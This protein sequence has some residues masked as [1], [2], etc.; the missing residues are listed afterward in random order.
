MRRENFCK[1]VNMAKK[2]YYEILGVSRDA[3]QEEIK[4]AYRKLVLKYHPDR[5]PPE[6]KKEAEEKFKEISE[7][8]DVLSDPQKRKL[9]DM[10][11]TT[12]FSQ[13]TGYNFNW[14]EFF[15]THASDFS[16]LFSDIQH[17][18]ENLFGINLGRERATSTR[19]RRRARGK[20]I[21]YR[22]PL[23]LE[24]LARGVEK[25][26]SYNRYVT[27]PACGGTGGKRRVCPT[28]KGRGRVVR[29]SRMFGFVIQ[30]QT[31]CPTCGG[32]GEELYEK[33]PTCNGKGL[34]LKEERVKIR[35]PAG[36]RGGQRIVVPGKGDDG[37]EGGPAGDL[38]V[39]VEEK[40]HPVFRR[41]GDNLHMDMDITVSQAVVGDDVEIQDILGERIRIKIP[42]GTQPG[43]S[44]RVKGRGMPRVDGKGRGDLV[45]HLNVRVP[46][47]VNGKAKKL[48]EEL[49]K[50]GY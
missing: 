22:L 3:T 49:K 12:D 39:E 43:D 5:V 15:Q 26:I 50:M 46:K 47:K 6:K 8:Y 31:T 37:R 11:G 35:I 7:A 30:S 33:C 28:C 24:E 1:I 10:Y 13:Q 23:T 20:N 38:Y 41:E 45:V 16:D 17:I 42:E 44:I 2:D 32:T 18:I 14:D 25:E 9:Y 40:P 29:T 36:I 4:R 21:L 19:T 48:F 27:C 34:V